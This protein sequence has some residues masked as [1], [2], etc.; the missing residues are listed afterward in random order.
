M[1]EILYDLTE[2]CKD[3]TIK[4]FRD[5]IRTTDRIMYRSEKKKWINNKEW[6]ETLNE[7][8]DTK[9][10]ELIRYKKKAE[11]LLDEYK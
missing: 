1:N 3:M 8:L 6:V 2:W 5:Y 4:N 9:I 10:R 7:W 11:K